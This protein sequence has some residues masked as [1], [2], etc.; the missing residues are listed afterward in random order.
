[1][2]NGTHYKYL[3]VYNR[4]DPLAAGHRRKGPDTGRRTDPC[5]VITHAVIDTGADFS[6]N[7]N[8]KTVEP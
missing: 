5:V 2:K 3:F 8:T 6:T 7:K 4:P 1:M